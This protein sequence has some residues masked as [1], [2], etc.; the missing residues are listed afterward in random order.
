MNSTRQS[1]HGAL[2]LMVEDTRTALG[3][4]FMGLRT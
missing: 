2:D 4:Q 1:I 3:N